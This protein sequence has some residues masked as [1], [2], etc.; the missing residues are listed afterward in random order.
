MKHNFCFV[1]EELEAIE[2]SYKERHKK[3]GFRVTLI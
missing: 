2:E 3:R 1:Y